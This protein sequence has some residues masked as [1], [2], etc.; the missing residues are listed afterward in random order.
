MINTRQLRDL[1]I[2]PTLQIMRMHSEAAVNLLLGTCAQES[3][4]GEY[5]AQINGPALGIFQMEPAT[6]RD[7][8]QNYI[9]YND[10]IEAMV[11]QDFRG[12]PNNPS[13]LVSDLRCATVMT[14]LH[15]RRRPEP[16]PKA[17]D[18]W[19][20]GAYWKQHYNTE[21]G[22]GTV[23]EFVRNFERYVMGPLS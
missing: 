22:R 9:A 18:V 3:A 15:Y 8:W 13:Q 17:D 1:V 7:I 19:G 20:L 21:N 11:R 2:V 23:E 5:I 12:R 10:D 14:R 6:F 4:M 16:L